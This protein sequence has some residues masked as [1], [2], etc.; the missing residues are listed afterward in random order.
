[1]LVVNKE[2][3]YVIKLLSSINLVFTSI[4]RVSLISNS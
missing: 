1:M 2:F 4:L 3:P